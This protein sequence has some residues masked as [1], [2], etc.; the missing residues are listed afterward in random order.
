[1]KT[2]DLLVA[3]REKQKVNSALIKRQ[4]KKSTMPTTL[5]ALY[6]LLLPLLK[7]RAR[8]AYH[9]YRKYWERDEASRDTWLEDLAKA[10][11]QH[12]QLRRDRLKGRRPSKK[13]RR[14]PPSKGLLL[15]CAPSARKNAFADFSAESS[16]P[17]ALISWLASRWS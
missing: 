12:E 10:R 17:S 3:K 9:A 6:A 11:A 7:Q 16:E 8:K 2:L 5:A 4:H 15:N 1:V 13:N 14:P